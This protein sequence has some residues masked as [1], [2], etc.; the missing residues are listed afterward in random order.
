[1]IEEEIK[2][3]RDQTPT[4]NPFILDTSQITGDG[5]TNKQI[6]VRKN[7]RNS[8]TSNRNLLSSE[9]HKNNTKNIE[10]D[11]YDNDDVSVIIGNCNI[12]MDNWKFLNK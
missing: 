9:T 6:P 1:V 12:L 4:Y 11:D 7:T 5:L 10:D 3:V 8:K 2:V